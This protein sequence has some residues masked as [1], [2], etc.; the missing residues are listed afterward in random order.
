MAIAGWS[1]SSKGSDSDCGSLQDPPLGCEAT[2]TTEC[3]PNVRHAAVTAP[4][5]ARLSS[6][7]PL[8]TETSETSC[9]PLHTPAADRVIACTM[10][11]VPSS[12][13]HATVTTPESSTSTWGSVEFSAAGDNGVAAD[14]TPAC[15]RTLAQMTLLLVV[16]SRQARATMPTFASRTG[17]EIEPA[18]VRLAAASQSP[19]A[20]RRAILTV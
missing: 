7:E 14:Q 19:P 15:E 12:T 20:G 8:S 11:W 6:G 17:S 5:V 3:A 4:L 9:T 18:P 13:C 16:M 1:A 2:W 10:V